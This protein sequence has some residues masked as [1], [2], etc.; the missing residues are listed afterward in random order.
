[1]IY[2]LGKTTGDNFSYGHYICNSATFSKYFQT[3]AGYWHGK[4]P[5]DMEDKLLDS[6]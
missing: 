4:M 6:S 2:C 3:E 5:I 1:M